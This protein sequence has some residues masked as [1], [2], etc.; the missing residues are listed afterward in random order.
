MTL[1]L[2]IM[3]YGKWQP[4]GGQWHSRKHQ[5]GGMPHPHSMGFASRTSYLPL[6]PLTP[7]TSHHEAGKMLALA[8]VLQACTEASSQDRHSLQGSQKISAVYGP[9]NDPQWGQ[10]CG[11]LPTQAN[12]R[13]TWTLPHSR[14]GGHPP[15]WRRWAI[16]SARPYPQTLRNPRF[17]EPA[18]QTTTPVTS[19]VPCLAS[20]PHS[21]PSQKGK[22]LWEG[23]DIDP[24]KWVQAYLERDNRLPE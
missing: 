20:K 5:D 23:I 9:F 7:R 16:G 8:Q 3:H 21:C 2:N 19:A 24:S 15:G 17:V 13:G 6:L 18:E 11:G 10:Y 14:R 22:K 1:W 12:Q 4:S